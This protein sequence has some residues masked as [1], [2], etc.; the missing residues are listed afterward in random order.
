ME[1][2][3]DDFCNLTKQEKDKVWDS[4]L[5]RL[6]VLAGFDPGFFILA[7]HSLVEAWLNAQ[8]PE[9]I[10]QA[11][12]HF[13][14]EQKTS[15]SGKINYYIQNHPY[16]IFN[17]TLSDFKQTYKYTNYVR[18]QFCKIDADRAQSVCRQLLTFS[19]KAS[20][21]TYEGHEFL[22]SIIARWKPCE[23]AGT[24]FMKL[25]KLKKQLNEKI[26]SEDEIQLKI[27]EL[28]TQKSQLEAISKELSKT[29]QILQALEYRNEK[30]DEDKD[31]LRANLNT[32][33][34]ELSKQTSI[35]KEN[36]KDLSY[37]ELLKTIHETNRSKL[38]YEKTLMKLSREQENAVRAIKPNED[39]LIKGSAGT[40]KTLVLLDAY[41]KL[42]SNEALQLG[43]DNAQDVLFLT[44]SETL[45][46]YSNYLSR[47]I[48][49][50]KEDVAVMSMYNFFGQ[51]FELVIPNASITFSYPFKQ[52][53][54]DGLSEQ[55][56]EEI[57]NFIWANNLNYKNYVQ[58]KIERKGRLQIIPFERRE[59]IWKKSHEL[60]LI[61]IDNNIFSKNASRYIIYSNITTQSK[62]LI[63]KI[64]DV[65]IVDEVQDL[66]RIDIL[67][68]KKLS[69]TLILAGDTRQ[70]IFEEC[71]SLNETINSFNIKTITLSETSRNTK[72]ILAL[73]K[74]FLDKAQLPY[75]K[76]N[77]IRD[78]FA[79]RLL[80]YKRKSDA[81]K[82][83]DEALDFYQKILGYSSNT[84][85]I[86]HA[87]FDLNNL[88][89]MKSY[90]SSENKAYIEIG[91]TKDWMDS[92]ALRIAE[93][94]KV[95]GIDFP[96]VILVIHKIYKNDS[97]LS[98][99]MKN[100]I[101]SNLLYVGLTRAIENLT[102]ILPD[103]VNDP[104]LK[105]VVDSFTEINK[106]NDN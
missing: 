23:E 92:D 42:K 3:L 52:Y 95:K 46:E 94:S 10:E 54:K 48:T 13:A 106:K 25:E 28:N 30:Q 44:Y 103:P 105:N 56:F 67:I 15:F 16:E 93:L 31:K 82:K 85:A 90:F 58:E 78:G 84:I 9:W 11:E 1:M 68:F 70:S 2:P 43:F 19:I 37:L 27:L 101:S 29:K 35:M 72:P 17:S 65:I 50:D 71:D 74:Y 63:R 51:F 86:I 38:E 77:S 97:V 40:G 104:I 80:T 18:H 89:I 8:Y 33:K 88:A 39:I 87:G 55:E 22:S 4:C 66:S 5:A 32:L 36:S 91:E 62:W 98:Q 75:D 20:L 69:T 73:S 83:I 49:K 7:A 24:L 12:N 60:L 41:K 100:T 34:L 64:T 57:E 6:K 26:Q 47:L 21:G 61:M 59:Y 76:V 79:P 14:D 102:V 45:G 81:V 99:E 96:V 53:M